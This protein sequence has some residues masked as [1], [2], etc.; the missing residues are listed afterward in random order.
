MNLMHSQALEGN[1][2]VRNLELDQ[3]LQNLMSGKIILLELFQ[4]PAGQLLAEYLLATGDRLKDDFF[5][6]QDATELDKAYLRG[7][8]QVLGDIIGLPAFIKSFKVFESNK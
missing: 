7:Q 2:Q 3:A 5:E 6:K 1:N 8:L 4:L